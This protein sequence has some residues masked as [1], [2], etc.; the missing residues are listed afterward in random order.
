[1]ESE[2]I[3]LYLLC[4]S[5]AQKKYTQAVLLN[6][7]HKIWSEGL[8]IY[9]NTPEIDLSLLISPCIRALALATQ[10]IPLQVPIVVIESG[11]MEFIHAATWM[12]KPV[13]MFDTADTVQ[14]SSTSNSPVSQDS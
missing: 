9:K 14:Y 12:T 13:G 2:S 10:V 8:T 11:T 3:C 5:L 4:R 6:I 1:M 7:A